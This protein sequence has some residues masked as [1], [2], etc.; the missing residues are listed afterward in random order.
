MKGFTLIEVL[1]ALV[2]M[3]VGMLGL[4]AIYIE[5]LRL[6]RS[7]V[8]HNAAIV[9]AADMAERLAAGSDGRPGESER[10]AWEQE[11]RK[12]LPD[13]STMNI[14]ATPIVDTGLA[15][16]A[17]LRRYDIQ[18]QWPE[19]GQGTPEIYTLTIHLPAE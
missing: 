2:V 16:G 18:L 12:Q 10:I 4:S 17:S 6:N 7:A 3:T 9:L 13:G 8:Y 11:V 5:S 14:R 15:Q 19:P 1:I